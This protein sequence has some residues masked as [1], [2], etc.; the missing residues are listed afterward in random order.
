M[1]EVEL[2][3]LQARLAGL[4]RPYTPLDVAAS[5]RGMGIVVT[6]ATV[7][8]VLAELRRHSIGAG[9][10]EELLGR[11]GVSDVPE[12]PQPSRAPSLEE[13]R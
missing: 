6:D 2:D 4:G 5:L 3:R 7:H 13:I 1:P 8:E 9:P 11:P 12:Y 10:L